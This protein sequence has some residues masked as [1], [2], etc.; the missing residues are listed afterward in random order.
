MGFQVDGVYKGDTTT[1]FSVAT[2]SNIDECGLGTAPPLGRW[3]VFAV[4]FPPDNGVLLC[5]RVRTDGTPRRRTAGGGARRGPT[6]DRCG[7]GDDDV[8]ADDA[9]PVVEPA[10]GLRLAAAC[11]AWPPPPWPWSGSCPGSSPAVA[12]SSSD[13][14]AT[15]TSAQ[16]AWI[17]SIS[18]GSTLCTSP[19]MPRSATPKIGASL[20][21]L[22]AM[23]CL[24]P[25]M[26]TMCWVAPEM[27]TAM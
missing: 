17:A 20:S 19:T 16:R 4:Q 21:L 12:A 3:L 7:S 27:P 8:T 11:P 26:P 22:I 14:A 23:M 1:A 24:E 6:T 2:F 15:A 18:F 9:A 10:D 25:F 13:R 5:Q